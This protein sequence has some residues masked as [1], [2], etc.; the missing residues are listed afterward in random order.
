MKPPASLSDSLTARF[1]LASRQAEIQSL[2]ALVSTCEVVTCI[3]RLIHELQ[4]ERGLTNVVLASGGVLLTEKRLDQIARGEEAAAALRSSLEEHYLEVECAVSARLYTSIAHVMQGLD[5][6]GRLRQEVNEGNIEASTMTNAFSRLIAGLLSVVTEAADS[7]GDPAVSRALVALLNFTQGKEYAGQ[8]RAWAAIGFASGHFEQDLKQ[9]LQDLKDAQ[10]RAIDVFGQF[11]D[12]GQAEAWGALEQAPFV[13]ELGKLRRV[14]EQLDAGATISPSISEVWYE[15]ATQRIDGMQ[16]I[17]T[18]LT[19][20]LVDVCQSRV[21]EAMQTL[22]QQRL[23]LEKVLES[24]PS[25]LLEGE[26]ASQ[27]SHDSSSTERSLYC[28]LQEQADHLNRVSRQL[29]EAREAL[30]ERKQVERAKSLLMNKLGLTEEEAFR[31]IQKRAMSSNLRLVDVAR[32]LIEA[33]TSA[34]SKDKR[35]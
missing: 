11:C 35:Q 7:A 21:N 32:I 18:G 5:D 15:L 9:R 31:K 22:D 17:E 16:V 14:V 1:Y 23:T 3:C 4:K 30:A 12:A 2:R 33:A 27:A 25:I 34:P 6:L 24:G 10:S 29:E 26:L 13:K 8:E 28:L 20:F 19:D